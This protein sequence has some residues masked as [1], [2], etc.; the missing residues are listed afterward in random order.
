[1]PTNPSPPN[2]QA[3]RAEIRAIMGRRP[4][5]QAE[6]LVEYARRHD[7]SALRQAFDAHELF[8]DERAAERARLAFARHLIQRV[9]VR[10]ITPNKAQTPLRVYVNLRDERKTEAGGYRLRSAVLRDEERLDMLRREFAGDI[11]TIIRRYADILEADQE[12]ALRAIAAEVA[13]VLH[14][15][16]QAHV[17]EALQALMRE[18]RRRK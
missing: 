5:F 13:G 3:V 15:P 14:R 18:G 4:M 11:E 10:L 12:E 17:S 16:R 8:D 1:M 9:K 6:D 7:D 2:Y